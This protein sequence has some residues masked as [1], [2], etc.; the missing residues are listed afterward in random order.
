[1]A[2]HKK[3][4]VAIFIGIFVVGCAQEDKGPSELETRHIERCHENVQANARYQAEILSTSVSEGRLGRT[5]VSGR[6]RLQNGYGAWSN[7]RY[8]CNMATSYSSD[9]ILREGIR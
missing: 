1:M 9:V 4:S 8:E 3:I 5:V 2:I 6:T 7:Y